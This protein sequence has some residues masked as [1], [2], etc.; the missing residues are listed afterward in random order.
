VTFRNFE[1]TAAQSRD[2]ASITQFI[3]GQYDLTISWKDVAWFKSVWGGP[4]AL[5]GVL[6]P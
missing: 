5:K 6:S 2:A 1:G 4:L 3:A